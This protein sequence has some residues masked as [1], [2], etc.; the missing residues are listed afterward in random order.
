MTSYS[1]GI[2]Q[3][4]LLFGVLVAIHQ[5]FLF[6]SQARARSMDSDIR[7]A[8]LEAIRRS[9]IAGPLTVIPWVVV[10]LLP[11]ELLPPRSLPSDLWMPCWVAT[12]TLP[13]TLVA[14]GWSG[15]NICVYAGLSPHRDKTWWL[16]EIEDWQRWNRPAILY[17]TA[18][19]PPAVLWITAV[20]IDWVQR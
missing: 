7:P 10:P 9:R 17:C 12:V 4:A 15:L 13:E 1:Q 11:L 5:V 3:D 16:R 6:V 8:V 2:W 14:L 18:L 20:L 19:V